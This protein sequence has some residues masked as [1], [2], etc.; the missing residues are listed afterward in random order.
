MKNVF[1]VLRDGRDVMVSFYFHSLF[2]NELSN[3]ALVERM[4]REL[5][6]KDFNDIENNLPRFIEYKFTKIRPPRFTWS[7]FVD[8]WINKDVAFVRYENLLQNT[9]KEVGQALE[10]LSD[11]KSDYRL[12]R[13]IA[14][15]YS[16]KRQAK[17]NPGQE[18]RSSF[19]RKGIAGD[20]KHNFNR[21]SR[22]VLD[23]FAGDQLIKL[24]YE[25]DRSWV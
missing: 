22:E 4:R 11:Q 19:L 14:E 21:D 24:G 6:F 23:Y 15:K 17:R 20:W 10:K 8:S 12:I 18:N 9:V 25:K 3:H 13:Q 7:E 1:V 2:K 16:F 5:P